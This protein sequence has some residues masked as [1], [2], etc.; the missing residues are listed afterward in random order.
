M[1]MPARN[2]VK[3]YAHDS[4]YHVTNK[5]VDGRKIFQDESDYE[6][7]IGLL[8]RYLTPHKLKDNY[9]RPIRSFY[10]TVEMQTYS[11]IPSSFHLVLFVNGEGR[12][13]S[14]F[15]RSVCTAYTTYFN[16][17]YKRSGHL[18]KGPYKAL[19]LEDNETVVGV[20]RYVHRKH[21]DYLTWPHSSISYFIGDAKS[22][23]VRPDKLYSFYEWGT[24]ESY[25]NDTDGFNAVKQDIKR[26]LADE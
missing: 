26:A 18:F 15:I 11:L 13:L 10:D 19:R 12:Q 24:Y 14:E 9:G 21:K 1:V 22:D 5:G 16:K 3:D 25:L 23:W 4:F 8:K 6:F 2:V 17:K 20:S 7:F